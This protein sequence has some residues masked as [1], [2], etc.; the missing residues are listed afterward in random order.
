V[1]ISHPVQSSQPAEP[2][3]FLELVDE[4]EIEARGRSL[5]GPARLKCLTAHL[6]Y[7]RG[8]AI[9]ARRALQEADRNPIGLLLWSLD[10]NQHKKAQLAAERQDGVED[11]PL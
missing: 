10:R 2:R 8:F 7:P 4:L 5:E 3:A 11:I 1:G 6:D 9:V